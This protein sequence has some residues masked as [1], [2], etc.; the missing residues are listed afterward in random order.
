[1]CVL[2][3]FFLPQVENIDLL[4]TLGWHQGKGEVFADVEEDTQNIFQIKG[5]N[6][7][8]GFTKFHRHSRHTIVRT[9]E[10][11]ALSTRERKQ[12]N[13]SYNQV[14]MYQGTIYILEFS[15]LSVE[16]CAFWTQQW[17]H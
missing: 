15:A 5:L 14:C 9:L 12:P 6:Y 11:A 10:Q 17:Q 3:F 7:C 1:M 4:T 8:T 2:N 13:V 16:G